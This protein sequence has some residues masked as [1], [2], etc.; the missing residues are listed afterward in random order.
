MVLLHTI[1]SQLNYPPLF[2]VA[3]M[4][5]LILY[6]HL[7]FALVSGERLRRSF[8]LKLCISFLVSS[9]MLQITHG[10][11]INVESE[12]DLRSTLKL[13]FYLQTS[14]WNWAHQ[15]VYLYLY[16]SFRQCTNHSLT[17]EREW[18]VKSVLQTADLSGRSDVWKRNYCFH[19]FDLPVARWPTH[20]S[21]P[22]RTTDV[23]KQ[24]LVYRLMWSRTP[25][26]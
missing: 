19:G 3:P 1:L 2:T 5:I 14:C 8:P 11:K 12:T 15:F 9:T 24:V 20:I 21:V 6:S 22:A 25:K 4:S 16:Q 13:G 26:R 17:R 7:L 18:K 10:T 23:H